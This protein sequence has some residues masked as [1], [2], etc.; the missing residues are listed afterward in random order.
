[1]SLLIPAGSHATFG[2][3]AST[4]LDRTSST[5]VTR[6]LDV[7]GV[8]SEVTETNRVVGA[9]TDIRLAGGYAPNAK[10]QAGI[11]GHVFTG[12]NRDFFSQTFPDTLKFTPITQT[13]T[14]AFTGYGVSAGIMLRP[15]RVFGIGLSGL[16][17]MKLSTRAG[18]TLVTEA[19]IPDRISGGISY[20]G[21]PGSSISARVSHESWSRLNGLAGSG[22]SAATDGWDGSFGVEAVGPRLAERTTILRLGARYRTLPFLAADGKVKELSFAAGLGAQFF[23]N[24]AALDVALER[25]MRSPDA[26]S[27]DAIKERAYIFSFGLRVRP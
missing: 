16:K 23:R 22:G 6:T 27:L 25:A 1:M 17:G 15:S 3:S 10:F 11:A 8:T 5:Q 18:D 2:L 13:S 24:R 9:I 20:E 7:A 21:I 14:L 4:F 12:Q 19:N 26:S